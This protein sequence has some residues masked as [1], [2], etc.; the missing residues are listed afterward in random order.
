M[1]IAVAEICQAKLDHNQLPHRYDRDLILHRQRADVLRCDKVAQKRHVRPD[2]PVKMY[3]LFG[4]A[5]NQTA[6]SEWRDGGTLRRSQDSLHGCPHRLVDDAR[7][8]DHHLLDPQCW[9]LSHVSARVYD[10]IASVL[11]SSRRRVPLR[12]KRVGLLEKPTE[13]SH[14]QQRHLLRSHALRGRIVRLH[15]RNSQ[16]G[17]ERAIFPKISVIGEESYA[18]PLQFTTRI[19]YWAGQCG[20][21]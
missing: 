18:E 13:D 21:Q 16:I 4:E 12:P 9:H 6:R 20:G 19:F 11:Y 15:V 8:E 14:R 3:I 10:E 17:R 1:V 7:I 5:V 2:A